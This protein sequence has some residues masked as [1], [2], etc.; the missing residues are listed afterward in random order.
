MNLLNSNRTS[1]E[2]GNALIKTGAALTQDQT[3]RFAASGTLS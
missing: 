2:T 1:K 3:N